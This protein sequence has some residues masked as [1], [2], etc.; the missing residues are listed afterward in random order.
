MLKR[1]LMMFVM[2]ATALGCGNSETRP[3]A[4]QQGTVDVWHKAH[5][6]CQVPLTPAARNYLGVSEPSVSLNVDACLESANVATQAAANQICETTVAAYVGS[7]I[8]DILLWKT[9]PLLD[10]AAVCGDGSGAPPALAPIDGA[11][12]CGVVPFENQGADSSEFPANTVGLKIEPFCANAY[13]KT[14]IECDFGPN[15]NCQLSSD[16]QQAFDPSICRC[17]SV[18]GCSTAL[19]RVKRPSIG[20]A[21]DPLPVSPFD[22]QAPI[23]EVALGRKDGIVNDGQL[24]VSVT[25]TGCVDAGLFEICDSDSDSDTSNLSGGF[26]VYGGPCVGSACGV[27]LEGNL[28]ASA[29]HLEFGLDTPFGFITFEEHDITDFIMFVGSGELSVPVDANGHGTIPG[30]AGQYR[31]FWRDNG[32]EKQA[33]GMFADPLGFD[34]DWTTKT[35]SVD[36]VTLNLGGSSATVSFSG[37]FGDSVL[38]RLG[39]LCPKPK[40]ASPEGGLAVACGV[41]SQVTFDAPKLAI[42]CRDTPAS[43]SGSVIAANGQ[44]LAT[45]IPIVNGA[46]TVPRG[47]LVVRWVATDTAGRTDQVDQVIKAVTRPTLAA[48]NSLDLGDRFIAIEPSGQR[49]AVSNTGFGITV[50]NTEGK[51][52]ELD[53]RSRATLRDRAEVNLLVSPQTPVR[54]NQTTL[55]SQSFIAPVPFPQPA[56]PTLAASNA[57]VFVESDTTRPLAP[58]AYGKVTMHPRGHLR[59]VAGDYAF[60][61]LEMDST[62]QL[63][64]D[65]SNGAIRV[66]VYDTTKLQGIYNHSPNAATGF[67]LA[68]LGQQTV[69]AETQFRGTLVVPNAS[70]N[71]RALNGVSHEGEFYAKDLKTEGGATVRHVPATCELP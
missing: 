16:P 8:Q 41:G 61:T 4:P 7:E 40:L 5:C 23:A 71:L 26:R 20:N 9:G 15:G 42:G 18:Q 50:L 68:Y 36:Q 31:A 44:T 6:A 62:S 3:P 52:G 59:L 25:A 69:Y 14:P 21:D 19:S 47:E 49:G 46:A 27:V 33:I 70:L 43:V 17:D 38:D 39:G 57:D 53:S 10:S 11:V 65:K 48:T 24:S 37:T 12:T 35:L 54:F 64:L 51:V 29:L 34:I 63:D 28:A 1:I 60:K 32:T 56:L 30:G 58:G 66:V 55:V 67:L 22:P 2:G 13:A 45:P